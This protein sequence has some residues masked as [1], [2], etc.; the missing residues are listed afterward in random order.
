MIWTLLCKLGLYWHYIPATS[1]WS[2]CGTYIT[3]GLITN[4]FGK[5]LSFLQTCDFIK[6]IMQYNSIWVMEKKLASSYTWQLMRFI[7]HFYLNVTINH[8]WVSVITSD[9]DP[10]WIL[11]MM[12]Q[13][14][15][16]VTFRISLCGRYTVTTYGAWIKSNVTSGV[17]NNCCQ[18]VI[19]K[20]TITFERSNE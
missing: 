10:M 19:S 14:M 13:N 20:V 1:L 5:F 6:Y 2:A 7:Q 17:T 3:I 11:V 18:K 15:L 16:L 9:C 8:Y 12:R 4:I